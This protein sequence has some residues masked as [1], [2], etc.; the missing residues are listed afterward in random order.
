MPRIPRGQLPGHAYHVLNR[1]NG[2]AVVFHK[3]VDYATFLALL[4]T[5]KS[6]FPVRVLGFCLMPNHF[7]LV[8]QPATADALS[9]IMQWWMTSH[10]RRYHRHYRSHGHVWQGRFKSFPIQQDD[11][12]L[13]VLRYVVRNPVRAQLVAS[14]MQWPWSSLQHPTLADPSPVPLPDNWLHWIDQPLFELELTTLRTC[15][16]RQAPFGSSD[17]LAKS[18]GLAGLDSTLRPRGRPRNTSNK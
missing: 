11:H 16:N 2:S 18:T 1:G 17:W 3:D 15:L 12:L 6:K 9:P 14:V 10:V 4:D 5:A 8:L 13:T 7:H